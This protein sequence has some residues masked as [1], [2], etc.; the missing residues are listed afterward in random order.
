VT[1]GSGVYGWAVGQPDWPTNFGPF[2]PSKPY[3]PVEQLASSYAD[4]SS[5]SPDAATPEAI[6]AMQ[7]TL[8]DQAK[9][10]ISGRWPSPL[11]VRVPDNA[12][13]S[14][15]VMIGFQQLIPGVWMP[16]RSS[17]TARNVVQWQKLDSVSVNYEAGDEQVAVVLSPAPNNGQDPD[18]DQAA[19]DA[20]N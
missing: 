1:N 16:L 11:I 14:P 18:A 12:T 4:T 8:S 10:N 3:G 13:L 2:G 5:A 17:N 9:R 7:K 6:A 19:A 20:A 15:R